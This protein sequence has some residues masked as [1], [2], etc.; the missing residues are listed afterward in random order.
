[1]L[2]RP[3]EQIRS[4]DGGPKL[5][6]P[7][8]LRRAGGAA[9]DVSFELDGIDGIKLAIEHAV[10][11]RCH[12]RTAHALRSF[13]WYFAHAFCSRPRARASRDMTVPIGTPVI[14]AIC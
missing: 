3:V 4:A 9:F 12:I 14:S 2:G 8:V 11:E 1:M 10:Q 6:L 5:F 7:P 13:S